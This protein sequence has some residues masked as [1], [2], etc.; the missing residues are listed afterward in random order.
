MPSALVT[1]VLISVP[2]RLPL[3]CLSCKWN[4]RL[5]SFVSGWFHSFHSIPKVHPIAA[6]VSSWFPLLWLH[7][8]L[9]H[10]HTTFLSIPLLMDSWV[11]SAL[12][13]SVNNAPMN[14]GVHLT[15]AVPALGMLLKRLWSEVIWYFQ[16][17]LQP[18]QAGGLL[19]RHGRSV[20]ATCSLWEKEECVHEPAWSCVMSYEQMLQWFGGKMLNFHS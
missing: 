18:E 17:L 16:Y 9:L 7:N 15:V 14:I 5:H 19:G 8:I 13:A 2:T 12:L 6:C 1:S 4:H 3:L 10:V 20:R 11:I